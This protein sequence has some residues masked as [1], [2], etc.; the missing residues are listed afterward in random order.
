[1]LRNVVASLGLLALATTV[2][3]LA[4]MVLYRSVPVVNVRGLVLSPGQ[5]F[6][7]AFPTIPAYAWHAVGAALGIGGL[8]WFWGAIWLGL[9]GQWTRGPLAVAGGSTA[10]AGLV[11]LLTIIIPAIAWAS[12]RATW[13]VAQGSPLRAVV[14]GAVG[15]SVITYIGTLVAILW[16]RRQKLGGAGKLYRQIRS[17]VQPLE[18]EVATGIVPILTVWAVLIVLAIMYALLLGLVIVTGQSWDAR[19]QV[20]LLVALV[21]IAAFVDQTWLSLHPFYRRRLASAFAVRREQGDDGHVVA[22]PY[23]FVGERT[24]LSCYGRRRPGFPQVIFAA[25]A[26]L[27]GNE[28]TPPGRRAVSF[29]F[30][31]DYVGGPD[32]GWVRTAGLEHA[33]SANLRSDVTV[34]TAMAVS[35]AAFAS[36]MGRQARAYQTLLALSNARLGT[37]LPNP[38]SLDRLARADG[39]WRLPR[40]P[41]VRRLSYL[42]R[43]VL[44]QFPYDDRLLL[45]TDGGHYENLGLVELLRHGCRLIYCIDAS[46]DAPPFATTLAEAIAL[47]WEELGVSIC[48]C[49]PRRLVPGSAEPLEPTD[50]LSALNARL[51]ERA[52]VVGIITYPSRLR[53][54]PDEAN[55]GVLVVAKASLTADMPYELLSYAVANPTFPRQST[56]DQ[57]FD[58]GQFDAYQALGRFIGAQAAEA[59]TNARSARHRCPRVVTEPRS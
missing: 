20:G 33:V 19:L 29:T 22:R 3:G 45:C 23:N 28:R 38:A 55:K 25:A 44:G 26:A 13:Q 50:P 9:H 6:P 37:W 27:S 46:G 16:R 36:A 39:D 52:V 59:A 15:S 10:V 12:A 18:R 24:T 8:A 56:A 40:L 31:S 57:F 17:A 51:S 30:S 2:L 58:S 11:A 43:E 49:E 1:V 7:P 21:L 4:L 5:E 42:I 32:V 54:G 34:Q 53:F 48:L 47:A 35:G 41:R 14:G